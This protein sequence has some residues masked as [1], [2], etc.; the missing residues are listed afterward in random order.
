MAAIRA[1]RM[2]DHVCTC[3]QD[4]V[5]TYVAGLA[6]HAMVEKPHGRKP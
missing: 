4:D 5:N 2:F 3:V 6:R 1:G